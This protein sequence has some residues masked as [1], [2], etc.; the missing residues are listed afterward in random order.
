[1]IS[2]RLML[3]DNKIISDN[4]AIPYKCFPGR[5]LSMYG[6]HIIGN[7]DSVALACEKDPMCKAFRHSAKHGFGYLCADSDARNGYNDWVLCKI[8]PG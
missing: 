3:S 5:C 7:N 1:M 4:V 6:Y 8:N 2:V